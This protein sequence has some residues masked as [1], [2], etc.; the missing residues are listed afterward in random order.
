M[1]TPRLRAATPLCT[2]GSRARL[3]RL[4]LLGFATLSSLAAVE[5]QATAQAAKTESEDAVDGEIISLTAYNVKADRIEDFGL[6][7]D[8][9]PYKDSARPNAVMLW[10]TTF[11]PLVTAIVPNTAAA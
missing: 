4:V 6:R 11:V 3:L 1:K 8:A 7:V 5:S 2:H 10:F 9:Q